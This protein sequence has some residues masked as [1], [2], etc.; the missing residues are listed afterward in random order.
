VD[1]KSGL[2]HLKSFTP[3]RAPGPASHVASRCPPSASMHSPIA[4]V[5]CSSA[6]TGLVPAADGLH[7]LRGLD[8]YTDY[9]GELAT[10][11]H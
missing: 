3:V 1:G 7:G 9:V 8:G 5:V 10:R 2:G 6:T 4:W 11:V